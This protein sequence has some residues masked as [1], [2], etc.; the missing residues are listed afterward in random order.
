[1]AL[2]FLMIAVLWQVIASLP[3][4]KAYILPKLSTVLHRLVTS[5]PEIMSAGKW[6]MYESV[7]GLLAAIIVA[8]PLAVAIV[9][10]RVLDRLLY[11]AVISFNSVPKIALVPLFVIWFGFGL[12][13]TIAITF[14]LTFFPILVNAILGFRGVERDLLQ[15]G[16]AMGGT[17]P[18]VFMR[19]RLP[20]ALPSIF[21]GVKVATSLAITGAIVSEFI[22]SDRGWGYLLVSAGGTLDSALIFAVVIITALAALILFYVVDMIERLVAP[23]VK[24]RADAS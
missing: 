9:Y 1:V 5:F 14:L 8:L 15:L 6:T 13:P 16:R 12:R 24:A 17:G 18:R 19:I 20:S 2:S 4:M 21:A 3:G 10:S 7:V 11:P 23:W 22:A